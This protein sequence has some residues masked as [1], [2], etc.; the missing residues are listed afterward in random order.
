[1]QTHNILALIG[2]NMM[3]I[4]MTAIRMTAINMTTI[5]MMTHGWGVK[6]I[7]SPHQPSRNQA[8]QA[9]WSKGL[10][11]CTIASATAI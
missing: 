9:N 7:L 6:I 8:A 2:L 1:M 3:T 10:F 11:F 5:R 4:R